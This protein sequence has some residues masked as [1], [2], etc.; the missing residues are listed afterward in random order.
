MPLQPPAARILGRQGR[1]LGRQVAHGIGGHVEARQ[2][3]Q[4]RAN[5][6]PCRRSGR[7]CRP[8]QT[9]HHP[10]RRLDHR[11]PPHLAQRKPP[12]ETTSSMTI[13]TP[14]PARRA[15][16]REG[17][18]K[19]RRNLN[20]PSSRS[21][22]DRRHAQDAARGLVAPGMIP[23][24]AGETHHVDVA[25]AWPQ[26]LGGQRLAEPLGALR[27]H[28]DQVLLQ[29]H[30]GL[31]RP[32]G[33]DE[34]ALRAGRSAA[35]NSSRIVSGCSWAASVTCLADWRPVIPPRN[36]ASSPAGL[37]CR[38]LADRRTRSGRSRR[39]AAVT[40]HATNLLRRDALHSIDGLGA[41]HDAGR[42]LATSSSEAPATAGALSIA[43]AEPAADPMASGLEARIG[44]LEARADIQTWMMAYGRTRD[45]RGFQAFAEDCARFAEYVQA[46]ACRQGPGRDPCERMNHGSTPSPAM[47]PLHGVRE[48]QE[49]PRRFKRPIGWGGRGDGA[50]VEVVIAAQLSS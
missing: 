10:A 12:V 4:R 5:S 28:E 6:R 35:R 44:R 34:N 24:T 47:P 17:A 38:Q 41:A 39:S 29:E 22:I 14:I 18:G 25:D 26:D 40:R 16:M 20:T 27:I 2:G 30:A 21:T 43:H 19:W 49:L 32:G 37:D 9:E 46:R 11:L 13:R 33:Q 23:P 42:A 1:E 45:R 48:T 50:P 7:R 36:I 31:C 3:H 8:A 15:S